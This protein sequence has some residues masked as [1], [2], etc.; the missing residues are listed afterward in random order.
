MGKLRGCPDHVVTI[1]C[2][3]ILPVWD[4]LREYIL[5]VFITR[6]E[7]FSSLKLVWSCPYVHTHPTL[8]L[9][10]LQTLDASYT[11]VMLIDKNKDKNKKKQRMET[12]Q[13]WCSGTFGHKSPGYCGHVPRIPRLWA[14]G[15]HARTYG[16]LKV[17]REY[18]LAPATH[19]PGK[20]YKPH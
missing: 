6:S 8:R 16:E 12:A 5:K 20:V 15:W 4:L 18:K 9:L 3:V 17:G 2:S 14:P 10:N 7:R 13:C 1:V 19:G 11:S